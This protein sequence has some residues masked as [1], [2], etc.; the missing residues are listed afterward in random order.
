MKMGVLL[1][2]IVITAITNVKNALKNILWRMSANEIVYSYS[3]FRNF[4]LSGIRNGW[5][6]CWRYS[7]ITNKQNGRTGEQQ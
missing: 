7:I 3:S 6:M 2:V 4:M 1:I 5:N